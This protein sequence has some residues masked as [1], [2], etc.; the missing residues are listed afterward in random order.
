[1]ETR[2]VEF[3]MAAFQYVEMMYDVALTFTGDTQYAERLT[4]RALIE[5]AKKHKH[6]PDRSVKSTLLTTLREMYR[7]DMQ[8]LDP[9]SEL[10]NT[11][12]PAASLA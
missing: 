9:S 11:N 10:F 2:T 1:M 6:A 8:W 3:E 4:R 7:D 12:F 5:A